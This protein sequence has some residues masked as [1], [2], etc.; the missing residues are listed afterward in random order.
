MMN[1]GAL[2]RGRCSDGAKTTDDA[3]ADGAASGEMAN[4]YGISGDVARTI[5]ALL[6][7][8]ASSRGNPVLGWMASDVSL[9]TDAATTGT[10]EEKEP[11]ADRRDYRAHHGAR[12]RIV[13]RS[14]SLV[15]Q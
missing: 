2:K 10:V 12:R 7:Q 8:A 15:L 1:C 3:G 11:G 5:A 6:P 4:G 14:V 13:Q 9:K